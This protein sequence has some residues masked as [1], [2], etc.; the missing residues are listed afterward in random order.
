M[1]VKLTPQ[2]LRPL[3]IGTLSLPGDLIIPFS[4]QRYPIGNSAPLAGNCYTYRWLTRKVTTAIEEGLEI[5]IFR[6]GVVVVVV[7]VVVVVSTSSKMKLKVS[8][9]IYFDFARHQ[10]MFFDDS[11]SN[12]FRFKKERKFMGTIIY[13]IRDLGPVIKI[14]LRL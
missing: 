9:G 3:F 8:T 1:L 5:F 4:K 11:V 6:R 10:Y 2:L 13:T 14:F 12:K 7:L